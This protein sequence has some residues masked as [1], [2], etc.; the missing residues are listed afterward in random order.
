MCP[1][2]GEAAMP[3]PNAAA[4]IRSNA[5][6][7]ARRDRPAIKFADRAWTHGEFYAESRRFAGLFR[8][9]L[10][11][12]GPAHVAVLLDN[13]PDYLFAFGGAAL[14]G[15]AV[16]GLNHTRAR[17]APAARPDP[18]RLQPGHHRAAHHVELLDPI[19][20]RSRRCSRAAASPT[21]DDP[22]RALGGD[23]ADALAG[24]RR[25]RPGTRAGRR[26]P[27]GADLHVGHVRRARR[28]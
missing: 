4:L 27:V 9:R 19:A 15:A 21:G 6:D 7:P 12:D 14:T 2:P 22:D 20:D 18:H 26:H 24:R 10:P 1:A 13:T 25:H 23:L 16:V 28:R 17:R 5:A 11:A 8:D 3:A